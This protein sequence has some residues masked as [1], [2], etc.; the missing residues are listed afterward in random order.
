MTLR[1][2]ASKV[3]A[4]DTAREAAGASTLVPRQ[5][6]DFAMDFGASRERARGCLTGGRRFRIQGVLPPAVGAP[7]AATIDP[8]CGSVGSLPD[9]EASFRGGSGEGEHGS[10]GPWARDG[11]RF[12]LGCGAPAVVGQRSGGGLRARRRKA[13]PE[14]DEIGPEQVWGRFVSR[15]DSGVRGRTGRRTTNERANQTSGTGSA[16]PEAGRKQCR[17]NSVP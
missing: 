17:Q 8:L 11:G 7:P 9:D 4:R 12:A 10:F 1:D 2:E 15:G 5:N 13:C 14:V 16:G 6:H 3:I